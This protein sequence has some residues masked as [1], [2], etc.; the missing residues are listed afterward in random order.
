MLT[1]MAIHPYSNFTTQKV[2]IYSLNAFCNILAF[3]TTSTFITLTQMDNVQM[4][5]ESVFNSLIDEAVFRKSNWNFDPAQQELLLWHY[6]LGRNGME[7]V[8]RLLAKPH[9]A[10]LLI[11]DSRL[12]IITLQNNKCSHCTVLLCA[13]YQFGK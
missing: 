3:I 7:T 2:H 4:P 5:H 1:Q 6:H 12:R 10:T 13:S 8:Q 9:S 11:S